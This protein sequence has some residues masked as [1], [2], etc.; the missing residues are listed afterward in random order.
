MFKNSEQNGV[1][2]AILSS[3]L[4]GIF[5]VLINSGV[6]SVSPLF[7][8]GFCTLIAS[9]FIFIY[10]FWHKQLGELKKKGIIKNILAITF[11]IVVIPYILLFTGARLTS[12]MNTSVLTLSEIIFTIIFTHFIGEKTTKLKLIG[13]GSIFLGAFIILYNGSGEIKIGDILI[14]F[15]TITYP[16]GNF[17]TKKAL[18]K[19]SPA[20]II[21]IR[22][23]LGGL[24]LIFLSFIFE[25]KSNIFLMINDHWLFLLLSGIIFMGLGKILAQEAMKRLDISKTISL[26]MT[27]PLFS[28]IFI[29]FFKHEAVSASQWLGIIIMMIGVYYSIKRKSTDP[30]LTKY[31]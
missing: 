6:K 5:L 14:F 20:I 16:L 31:A 9:A 25:S 22:S 28:L 23:L 8:A 1:Y 21:F 7:F 11:F 24:F 27:F 4:W 17:Y 3:L 15:S 2:L 10:C 13:A 30:S 12:S 19:L 18:N 29:I 26:F